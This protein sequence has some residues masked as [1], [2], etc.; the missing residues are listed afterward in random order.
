MNADRDPKL[1]AL[2]AQAETALDNA[3]FVEDVMRT[4]D[5]HRRNTMIMWSVFV[6][7]ALA[8]FALFASPVVTAVSMATELLP[9]SL[10]SVET[11]WMQKLLAPINSV[12]AAL[13]LG[14]LALRKF[15]RRIFR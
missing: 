10:V 11:D 13:A 4:I 8:C 14:V 15:Y 7:A 1:M 6:I 2:F 12:A 9:S 3:A 5:R